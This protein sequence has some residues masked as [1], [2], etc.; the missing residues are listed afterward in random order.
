MSIKSRAVAAETTLNSLD[1][2]QQRHHHHLNIYVITRYIASA[3][4]LSVLL[5]FGAMFA[6]A[7]VFPL[8]VE[9]RQ[10]TFIP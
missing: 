2:T 7:G 3:R 9:R 10:A 8:E 6:R 1:K 4:H 5:K